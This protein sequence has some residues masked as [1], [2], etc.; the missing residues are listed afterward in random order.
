[1][2]H[3]NFDE[4]N[5]TCRDPRYGISAPE[6]KSVSVYDP[7]ECSNYEPNAILPPCHGYAESD[8]TKTD[9]EE[10][11]QLRAQHHHIRIIPIKPA[12]ISMPEDVPLADLEAFA[13][14]IR[15]ISIDSKTHCMQEFSGQVVSLG[16][17]KDYIYRLFISEMPLGEPAVILSPPAPSLVLRLDEPW[18]EERADGD[19]YWIVG[20]LVCRSSEGYWYHQ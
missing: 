5:D 1:V 7:G 13:S 2:N 9:D 17:R 16:Q 19:T 10:V 15:D 11:G 12:E 8:F 18:V 4:H 6:H 3:L 14:A 20:S